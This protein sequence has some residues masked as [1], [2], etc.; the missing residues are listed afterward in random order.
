MCAVDSGGQSV[1]GGRVAV[2]RVVEF[3][4][5]H[6]LVN[7]AL[8]DAEN[9]RVFG[10]CGNPN[11]HGHNYKLEV[12]VTGAVD[13]ATGFILDLH[14]LDEIIQKRVVRDCDHRNLNLDVDWLKGTITTLENLVCAFASRLAAAVFPTRLSRIRLYETE[15]N[16]A[17]WTSAERAAQR[18]SASGAK[19]TAASHDSRAF[20]PDARQSRAKV[21]LPP[22]RDME[23][24]ASDIDFWWLQ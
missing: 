5:A 1:A 18:E 11:W 7:P 12:T 22:V 20:A 6:R 21:K 24:T 9:A 19:G 10:K 16:F 4:A 23:D 14:K 13:P 2:T 15:R 3:S 8:G 17:E